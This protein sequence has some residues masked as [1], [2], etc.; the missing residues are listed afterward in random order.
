MKIYKCWLCGRIHKK[1][2]RL[3]SSPPIC[4]CN[5]DTFQEITMKEYRKLK[6]ERILK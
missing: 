2:N 4:V 5:S 6:L 1:D 3:F